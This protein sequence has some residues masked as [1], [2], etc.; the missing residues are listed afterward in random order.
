MPITKSIFILFILFTS[1]RSFAGN[2][3]QELTSMCKIEQKVLEDQFLKGQKQSKEGSAQ[4]LLNLASFRE[5]V[6]KQLAL[7]ISSNGEIAYKLA[8]MTAPGKHI[9]FGKAEVDFIKAIKLQDPNFSII[10]AEKVQGGEIIIQVKGSKKLGARQK[11]EAV[12]NI[13]LTSY[14]EQGA[15]EMIPEEIESYNGVQYQD[16]QV[17]EFAQ[18]KEKFIARKASPF[19]AEFL[20][21]DKPVVVEKNR[22]QFEPTKRPET[23]IADAPASEPTSVDAQ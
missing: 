16:K 21:A 6:K 7:G 13:R 22:R 23:I 2:F 17:Q 5:E 19:C 12:Q 9:V 18:K 8:A 1:S 14:S 15:L 20:G 11:Y 10:S 3:E 4:A